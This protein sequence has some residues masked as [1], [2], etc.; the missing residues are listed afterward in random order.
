[1]ICRVGNMLLTSVDRAG[2]GSHA[3]LGSDKFWAETLH[4]TKAAP[5][6]QLLPLLTSQVMI[7]CQNIRDAHWE[8]METFWAD[9]DTAI[10]AGA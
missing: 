3:R 4:E 5:A 8:D 1:T 2:Q 6:E 10:A 9:F 7:H